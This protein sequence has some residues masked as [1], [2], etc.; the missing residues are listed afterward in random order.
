[1]G[2]IAVE[3]SEV[4][5]IGPM[6]RILYVSVMCRILYITYTY[7]S[8]VCFLHAKNDPPKTRDTRSDSMLVANWDIEIVIASFVL[9]VTN[10]LRRRLISSAPVRTRAHLD[11]IGCTSALEQPWRSPGW[12]LGRGLISAK[13]GGCV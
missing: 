3:P 10:Q 1:M 9:V 11:P 8:Y 12:G 13:I 5:K 6:C 4:A 7:Y 2:D